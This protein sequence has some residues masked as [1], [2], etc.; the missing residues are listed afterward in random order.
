MDYYKPLPNQT[1]A[2]R[3]RFPVLRSLGRFIRRI[4]ILLLVFFLFTQLMV[5]GTGADKIRKM[6]E[7]STEK[8]YEA[9]LIFGA[10]AEGKR[11]SHMLEDRL[12]YGIDLYKKGYVQ[13]LLLSGDRHSIFYDEP[14]VMLNYCLEHGV[15]R[16]ALLVDPK[17]FSTYESVMRAREVFGFSRMI[18]VT[19]GYHLPRALYIGYSNSMEVI[20]VASDPRSYPFMIKHYIREALAR[21]KDWIYTLAEPKTY[22]HE[23]DAQLTEAESETE[24]SYAAYSRP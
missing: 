6:D 2:K 1:Y 24:A 7:I 19:Q 20:G 3:R 16:E 4:L 5:Y 14:T 17:G 11:P 18:F 23:G 15:P 22:L 21:T 12:I 8:P 9:A 13:K 10:K